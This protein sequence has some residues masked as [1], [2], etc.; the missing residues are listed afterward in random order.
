[1]IGDKDLISMQQARILAENAAAAQ[2]KLAA[3]PQEALD[4]MV[5]TMADAVEAQAQSLAV[6]S[7]EESDCGVWQDKLVKIL[8]VC[9]RVRQSLRGLRCVGPLREDPA[10]GIQEVGVPLG[11]IAA[12][13]PVTSPIST[14][15]CNA[16]LAIKSGNAI[17]FSLHPRA[18]ESMR[19]ALDVLAPPGARKA[20]PKGPYPIWIWWPKAARKSLC[21]TLMWP[22]SWLPACWACSQPRAPAASP[23]FMA[24]RATARPLSSVAPG[25]KPPWRTSWPARLLTT[26]WPLRPS[27]ASLWTAAW[28]RGCAGPFRTVAAIS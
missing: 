22:W 19:T 2:K 3:M 1:M 21:A 7:Q 9:R 23:L 12:L 4:A 5:E 13:C 27:S 11:V 26:A 25:W 16:L 20:C 17:V 14:A 10:S 24:A 15:I 18:L 8:F 6:M 28:N